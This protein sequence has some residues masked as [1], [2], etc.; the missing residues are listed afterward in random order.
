[1]G[2]RAKVVDLVGLSLLDHASQVTCVQDVSVMQLEIG[3]VHMQVLLD[4]VQSLGIEDA[5]ESLDAL[6]DLAFCRT[7]SRR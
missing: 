3:V 4:V 7:N 6:D 5:A 1:M 2:S